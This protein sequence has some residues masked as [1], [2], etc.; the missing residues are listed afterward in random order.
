MGVGGGLSTSTD[1]TLTFPHGYTVS[2]GQLLSAI[3][4]HT[5]I[6]MIVTELLACGI[7]WKTK[8]VW[9]FTACGALLPL[10]L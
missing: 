3:A 6:A 7:Q 1:G 8:D 9:M 4:T 5:L 10:W 2:D